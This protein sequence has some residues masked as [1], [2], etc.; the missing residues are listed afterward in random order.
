MDTFTAIFAILY[1][2]FAAGQANQ[3]GPDIGQGKKA[4]SKVFIMTETPTEIDAVN[5][6]EDANKIEQ[7]SFNG[8]IEFVDVWFRYPTRPN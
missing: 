8:D 2:A 3:F 4:A 6:K 5:I 1:G 7:G